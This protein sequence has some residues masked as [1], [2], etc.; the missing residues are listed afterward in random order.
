MGLGL[1]TLKPWAR[2]LQI[3]IAGLGLLVCPFTLASATVLFY[4]LREDARLY[5]SGKPVPA[6]DEAGTGHRADV[7]LVARGD[8]GGGRSAHRAR[9]LACVRPRGAP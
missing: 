4:M 6:R 3:G 9:A 8:G 5:F 7:R 1:L 2:M